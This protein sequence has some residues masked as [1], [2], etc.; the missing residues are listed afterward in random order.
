MPKKKTTKK[1]KKVDT[2]PHLHTDKVKK[3]VK[4]TKE[5]KTKELKAEFLEFL[6]KNGGNITEACKKC[7]VHRST[8]YLWREKDPEFMKEVAIV[9]EELL[10]MAET[11]LIR[12]IN[13]SDSNSHM[14]AVIFYL[15]TQGKKRG[16]I[17]R[18]EFTG[19]DGD[20]LLQLSK[21]HKK[22][23]AETYLE[24]LEYENE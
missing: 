4:K 13:N 7:T 15:K 11:Q 22:K 5:E 19:A 14:T 12:A 16:Y 20:P 18:S 23:I 6:H 3:K 24:S 2:R 17:E 21:D 9:K 10:D 1:K 8:F